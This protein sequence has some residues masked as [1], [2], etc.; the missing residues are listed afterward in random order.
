MKLSTKS[1]NKSPINPMSLPNN[2]FW[3]EIKL[4]GKNIVPRSYHSSVVH[5]NK[6]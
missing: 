1:S 5:K 4:T 2:Q 3:S 6:Y